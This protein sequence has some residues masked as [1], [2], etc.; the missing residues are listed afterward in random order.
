MFEHKEGKEQTMQVPGRR[1]SGQEC[2]IA[3]MTHETP[4]DQ[5]RGDRKPK[6]LS[7]RGESLKDF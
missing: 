4:R 7:A 6:A 1:G 2:S 5:D 3:A